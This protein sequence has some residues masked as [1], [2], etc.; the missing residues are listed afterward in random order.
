MC[1]LSCSNSITCDSLLKQF[2]LQKLNDKNIMLNATPMKRGTKNMTRMKSKLIDLF[3]NFSTRKTGANNTG[4][5]DGWI[6]G[7]K[8]CGE[9]TSEGEGSKD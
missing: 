7:T 1:F 3:S 2:G 9:G 5:A 6:T 4:R 8:S